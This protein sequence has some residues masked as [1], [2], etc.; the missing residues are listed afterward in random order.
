LRPCADADAV[1]FTDRDGQP[2]ANSNPNAV[3]HP[4]GVGQPFGHRDRQRV[5][6]AMPI[7]V[8][9]CDAVTVAQRQR[10]SLGLALS[11]APPR[12]PTP[13]E[14][15]RRFGPVVSASSQRITVLI[16]RV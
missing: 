15:D 1:R 13:G 7:A 4:V 3:A 8:C 2:D 16:G 14:Q 12:H 10:E 5:R 9:D 11:Q 6:D